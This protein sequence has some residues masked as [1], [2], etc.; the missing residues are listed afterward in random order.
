MPFM[1]IR[2]AIQSFLGG[3]AELPKIDGHMWVPI[4]DESTYVYNFMC[5]YDQN[6]AIT[7]EFIERFETMLGRG[8]EDVLPGYK[9]KRNPANDY[10]IDREVQRTK[11]YTGITGINTQDFALQE[12]MGPI[13]D[14]SNEHLGTSDRAIIAMR[15][16]LLEGRT[17][18]GGAGAEGHRSGHL[19]QRPRLRRF[20]DAG[21]DWQD[22]FAGEIVAKW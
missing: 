16:M 6:A 21:R 1:Q 20:P 10:F 8:K 3:R 9:L 14:R 13:V 18:P 12:G 5:A 22:R 2:G 17:M 19:S 7:A 15:Q 4:D 11:T